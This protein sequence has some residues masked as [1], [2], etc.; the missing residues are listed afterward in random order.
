MLVEGHDGIEFPHLIDTDD[1]NED[2]KSENDEQEAVNVMN[3]CLNEVH[4]RFR[5][6][7]HRIIHFY[8]IDLKY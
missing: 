6:R 5:L 7:I 8:Y 1:E 3:L 2:K 4:L